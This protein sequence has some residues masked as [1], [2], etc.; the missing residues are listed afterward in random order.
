MG[1]R[2]RALV[3]VEPTRMG[4]GL[5]EGGADL[6]RTGDLGGDERKFGLT[7]VSCGSHYSIVALGLAGASQVGNITNRDAGNAG[8]W[9]V[10]W[11]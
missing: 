8:G 9:T 4:H 7:P 3:G 11:S 5:R 1:W 10:Q 6:A 2:G